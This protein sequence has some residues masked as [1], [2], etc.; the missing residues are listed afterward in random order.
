MVR[1][2]LGYIRSI[3]IQIIKIGSTV[4]F[5]LN[6]LPTNLVLLTLY[7]EINIALIWFGWIV[8]FDF[9]YNLDFSFVAV[10]GGQKKIVIEAMHHWE[11]NTCLKFREKSLTDLYYIRFRS[12][13]SGYY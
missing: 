6:F 4:K 12:D 8:K 13:T 2:S 7:L 10:V 9:F 11:E 3:L 1:A 5:R